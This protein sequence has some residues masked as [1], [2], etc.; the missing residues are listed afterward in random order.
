MP[1]K[2]IPKIKFFLF[3]AKLRAQ[4]LTISF[5]FPSSTVFA[6]RA[7]KSNKTVP[8]SRNLFNL[9]RKFHRKRNYVLNYENFIENFNFKVH[10]EKILA[11]LFFCSTLNFK[12]S[13]I[14]VDH[15]SCSELRFTLNPI[16]LCL[17][18][19]HHQPTRQCQ[20]SARHPLIRRRADERNF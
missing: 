19:S 5:E 13:L 11:I 12:R 15:L 1:W 4:H 16:A 6:A 3:L 14:H 7:Q 10:N 20:S 8:L 2:S 18:Q 17:S 9:S